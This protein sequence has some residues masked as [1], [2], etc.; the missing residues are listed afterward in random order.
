MCKH[1][2]F[3]ITLFFT[4]RMSSMDFT[5]QPIEKLICHYETVAPWM[6][7]ENPKNPIIAICPPDQKKIFIYDKAQQTLLNSISINRRLLSPVRLWYNPDGNYLAFTFRDAQNTIHHGFF[8]IRL[9]KQTILPVFPGEN[10]ISSICFHPTAPIIATFLEDVIRYWSINKKKYCLQHEK[11]LNLPERMFKHHYNEF[12]F[13]SDGK[14]IIL[15]CILKDEK[16]RR[17]LVVPFQ[18][19]G[20]KIYILNTKD[21]LFSLFCLLKNYRYRNQALLPEI[22]ESLIH[23]LLKISEL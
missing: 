21:T 22:I 12:S 1:I 17:E 19:I 8:D 23:S 7:K 11:Q 3:A 6:I 15:N 9:R 2:Y 14:T 4:A 16:N 5:N 13:S 10:F 20:E 18:A